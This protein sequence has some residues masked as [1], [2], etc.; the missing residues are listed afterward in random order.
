[1]VKAASGVRSSSP[2]LS[3]GYPQTLP[4]V[5]LAACNVSEGIGLTVSFGVF[6]SSGLA[7]SSLQLSAQVYS[8]VG[9][10]VCHV[11]PVVCFVCMSKK[12]AV[13]L[14]A[15]GLDAVALSCT[16]LTIV[17]FLMPNSCPSH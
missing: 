13:R 6:M 7:L 12:S 16:F 5:G 8:N 3:D 15:G 1:M 11:Q 17:L 9:C 14:H 10:V 4:K 2:F